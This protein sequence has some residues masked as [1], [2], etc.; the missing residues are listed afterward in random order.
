MH[1]RTKLVGSDVPRRSGPNVP[2]DIVQELSRQ[3]RPRIDRCGG[4]RGEMIVLGAR[5]DRDELIDGRGRE[6]SCAVGRDVGG[7]RAEDDVEVDG[8]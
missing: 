3:I 8:S 1:N 5:D 7:L 6:G 2:I 4:G